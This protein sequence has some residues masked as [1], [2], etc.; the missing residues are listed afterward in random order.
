M[1]SGLGFLVRYMILLYCPDLEICIST[2]VFPKI[3]F[4]PKLKEIFQNILS[5]LFKENLEISNL[6]KIDTLMADY[7]GLL[8]NTDSMPQFSS[9]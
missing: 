9:V 4:S 3:I 7:L 6:C 8:L 2:T 5:I 1:Q